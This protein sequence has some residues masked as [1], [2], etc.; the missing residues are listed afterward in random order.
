MFVPGTFTEACRHER[1]DDSMGI[2]LL[3]ELA[4]CALL[5]TALAV[6]VGASML[7]WK[8]A[9]TAVGGIRYARTRLLEGRLFEDVLFGKRHAIRALRSVLQSARVGGG[10]T[11]ASK[12]A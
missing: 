5:A 7:A 9:E 12:T 1:R 10:S 11:P 4:C 3:K 8:T 6:L 2:Y